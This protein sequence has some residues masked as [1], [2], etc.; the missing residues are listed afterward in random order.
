[1]PGGCCFVVVVA[2]LGVVAVAGIGSFTIVTFILAVFVI[3]AF[4]LVVVVVVDSFVLVACPPLGLA[5]SRIRNVRST[6]L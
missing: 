1:M 6:C 4:V 5:L 2:V 3:I